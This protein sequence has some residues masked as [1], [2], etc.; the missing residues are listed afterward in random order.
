MTDDNV[1]DLASRKPIEVEPDPDAPEESAWMSDFIENHFGD[2]ISAAQGM[3]H[4]HT[5]AEFRRF[6]AEVEREV[7]AWPK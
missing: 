6:K 4:A 3:Q 7:R 5:E 1:I 2:F